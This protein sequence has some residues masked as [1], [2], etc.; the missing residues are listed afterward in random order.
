MAEE[1]RTVPIYNAYCTTCGKTWENKN[2]HA[3]A[4]RH[5][6]IHKHRVSVEKTIIYMY[7]HESSS[8]LIEEQA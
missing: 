2:A 6:R 7:D 3:V 5:A 4:A 1:W 8:E